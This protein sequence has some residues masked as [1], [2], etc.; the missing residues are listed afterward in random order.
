MDRKRACRIAGCL[1][2]IAITAAGSAFAQDSNYWS[3]AYGTRSQLLGGVVIGSP[4]D[5]SAVFYNPG[6]LA[7][8]G[9]TELLLAGNAYQY[10]KV[11]VDNGS[12]P[13]RTLVSSSLGA[14]PSLFAGELPI[15]DKDRLAY[16]F[17]TR[18]SMDMTLERR[19]T[20][21]VEGLVPIANPVFAAAEVQLKQKFS[22]SWYGATWAHQLSP[23]IGF[24]VSPFVVARSQN[25]RAALL[26]EGQDAAGNVALRSLSREFSY[27]H[28]GVLARIGLSGVRDSL[29]WGITAT[30]PNLQ[31]TG[32]GATTYNTTLTDQTG[33]IGN[34]IGASYQPGL[35]AHYRTPLGVGAGASY[36]RG[37][38][39]VHVAVDWNGKVE[40]YNVLEPAPFT[41]STPSG[42]STVRVVVTERLDE[43][44]NWGIG[45]GH[46]FGD[47]WSGYASYHT[48]ASGRAKDDLPGNSLTHWDLQNFAV[49]TTLRVG[50]SDF[51]FGLTGAFAKE[52]VTALPGQPEGGPPP[53]NL[54][55][56]VTMVT[57]VVGWKI[58]F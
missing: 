54:E 2:M 25:T 48:D 34:V 26:Q 30:T 3:T 33:T 9:P 13:G 56:S 16:A 6:A 58:A 35:T 20:V 55:T 1:W 36:G 21:G 5:I 47:T 52:P 7:L 14:V 4:G 8:A 24:G 49:G 17:L 44:M 19:S 12:G 29:T 43:V 31:V 42:D 11:S 39:R 38:T 23:R 50:R 28:F 46:R 40:R 53:Q 57:V 37:A 27:L 45:V 15:L 18:R 51:A 41:V 22:E 10:Q 32:S